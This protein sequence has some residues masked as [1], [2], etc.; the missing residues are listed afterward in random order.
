MPRYEVPPDLSPFSNRGNNAT[1][2]TDGLKPKTIAH[3]NLLLLFIANPLARVPRRDHPAQVKTNPTK[4][5]LSNLRAIFWKSLLSTPNPL[6]TR[7]NQYL[8]PATSQT[9]A[10]LLCKKYRQMGHANSNPDVRKP[11]YPHETLVFIDP[12]S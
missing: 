7:V 8:Q 10:G 4:S 9:A 1:S 2:A 6:K 12:K 3:T 5:F 11:E